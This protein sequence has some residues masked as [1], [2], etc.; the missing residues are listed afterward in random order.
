MKSVEEKA[1]KVGISERSN[2]NISTVISQCTGFVNILFQKCLQIRNKHKMTLAD[3][4][5]NFLKNAIK[6]R[7][8]LSFLCDPQE[9]QIQAISLENKFHLDNSK[10][11]ITGKF[12]LICWVLSIIN[13]F[14]NAKQWT[15]KC[16]KTIQGYQWRDCQTNKAVDGNFQ[17]WDPGMFPKMYEH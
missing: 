7:K 2:N 6:K 8:T 15:S 12:L 10:V 9:L 1:S 13:S 11:H 3:Q 4:D 14:C 16:P 17:E 5:K